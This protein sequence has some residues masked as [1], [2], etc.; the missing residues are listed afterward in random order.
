LEIVESQPGWDL[1]AHQRV[2]KPAHLLLDRGVL[3][4][5]HRP[6]RRLQV[7]CGMPSSSRSVPI[8]RT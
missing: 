2:V 7:F 3:L 8:L 6:E 4:F 5:W 1:D